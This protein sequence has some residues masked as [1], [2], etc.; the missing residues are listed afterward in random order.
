MMTEHPQTPAIKMLQAHQVSFTPYIF[1]Y[2]DKG[3]TS[4]SSQALGVSEHAVVK[5][6]IMQTET[7]SALVVLMHGDCKVATKELAKQLGVKKVS[8]AS[9]EM[10][11]IFSGYLVGGTSPF[12]TRTKMPVYLEKSILDLETIYINGGQRGFLVSIAPSE[13][14]RVLQPTVV[15]VGQEI[16]KP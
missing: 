4:V 13:L 5:T 6:L 1:Q 8:P 3:G 7:K 12:G 2:E 10:A 15:T 16:T 14:V 11:E 9:P